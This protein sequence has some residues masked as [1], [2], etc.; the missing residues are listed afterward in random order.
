MRRAEAGNPASKNGP[1]HFEYEVD[2]RAGSVELPVVE[3]S[4]VLCFRV[5]DW[6]KE[7]RETKKIGAVLDRSRLELPL[8]VRNWRAGDAL[9]PRGHQKA[10]K[11]GRLL[12]EKSISRWEKAKLPVITSGGKLAWVRGLPEA[13]EFAVGPETREAVEITEEPL[14]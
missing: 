8:I 3:L 5:I 12:N 9:R 2:L 11:L 10:H 1:R 4:T 6:P 13:V 14:S 7:G